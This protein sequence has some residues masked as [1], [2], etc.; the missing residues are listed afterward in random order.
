MLQLSDHHIAC[1]NAHVV[2]VDVDDGG[3]GIDHT[4]KRIA[5]EGEESNVVRDGQLQLREGTANAQRKH[6]VFTDDSL[7]QTILSGGQEG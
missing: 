2:Y 7:R 1:L 3:G 6:A 5:V 4:G